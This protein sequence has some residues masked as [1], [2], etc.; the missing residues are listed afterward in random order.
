MA[1]SE[2]RHYDLGAAGTTPSAAT[3]VSGAQRRITV[4]LD[5]V[6]AHLVIGLLSHSQLDESRQAA[7]L[8]GQEG[9]N[10]R[11]RSQVYG[12]VATRLADLLV[13]PCRWLGEED[14]PRAADDG[15]PYCRIHADHQAKVHAIIASEPVAVQA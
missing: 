4:E 2:P 14:C 11:I 1:T 3:I 9:E 13:P 8:H 10:A 15:G 5:A 6:E 12:R 7:K